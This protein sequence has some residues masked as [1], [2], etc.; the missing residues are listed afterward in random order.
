MRYRQ[1]QYQAYINALKR[2]RRKKT[3]R[4]AW[5]FLLFLVLLAV[6]FGLQSNPVLSCI[7]HKPHQPKLSPLPHNHAD[8]RQ[9]TDADAPPAEN[10]GARLPWDQDFG[11]ALKKVT[12]TVSAGDT[13]SSILRWARVK[14]EV[15]AEVI[16]AL[17]TVFDPGKLREGHE[18]SVDFVSYEGYKP[19]FQC[20]HLKL[21]AREKIVVM[22]GI[23]Q[24]FKARMTKR[25]LETRFN[26]ATA[27][28]QSSLY[29]AAR[30]A[31]LPIEI[32]MQMLRAYV[33]DIDFQRDIH[34]G[35]RIE[36][37]YEEKVDGRSGSYVEAGA[38]HYAA[39]HTR[40]RVLRVYRHETNDGFSRLFN[41]EGKS[42]RKALMLTPIDGAHISSGYGMRKHP[43]L[44]YNKMHR[45]L[46]FAAPTGTPIMAAGDGVV[47]AVGP[48]GSYGNY[49]R[50]RHPN[51]YQTVYGHLSEFARGIKSGVR[52]KQG[53]IIGYVGSTG[54]STG[55]HLHFEVRR[56]GEPINPSSVKTPPGR[57]LEGKELEAFRR[58]KNKLDKLYASFSSG[59]KL[60][61][62]TE[63][64]SRKQEN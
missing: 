28:I 5:L 46:D 15:A 35:D 32:L 2:G 14:D 40:D 34:P 45:G 56:G 64:S 58:T 6:Y 29:Q 44:G 57:T 11:T 38:V 10:P 24:G 43:I 12:V 27:T 17:Q 53:E 13:L 23:D 62:R 1:H 47:E 19:V 60:A 41:S 51:L 30:D 50:I 37:L 52:V 59:K 21:N 7:P 63:A 54:R 36:V 39:V 3:K 26:Q 33:Y 25:D 48:R 4:A 9:F 42:I 31:D 61:A 18:M 22:R 20:L 55:P 16:K 49:I 8:I